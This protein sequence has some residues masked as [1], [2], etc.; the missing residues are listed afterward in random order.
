MSGP[1]CN[2]CHAVLSASEFEK[3]IWHHANPEALFESAKGC[4]LCTFAWDAFSSS[5]Q[6]SHP[7][8]TSADYAMAKWQDISGALSQG[9]SLTQNAILLHANEFDIKFKFQKVWDDHDKILQL[10]LIWPFYGQGFAETL[11][12]TH[13]NEAI[14]NFQVLPQDGESPAVHKAVNFYVSA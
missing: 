5:M 6:S 10:R 7:N 13:G 4:R 14:S 12:F 3:D 1:F 9:G 2:L 11:A 8:P